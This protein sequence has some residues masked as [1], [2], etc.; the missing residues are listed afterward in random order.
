MAMNTKEKAELDS[1][2]RI[3]E[4]LARD[5]VRLHESIQTMRTIG[6]YERE[7]C[8]HAFELLVDISTGLVYRDIS[9]TQEAAADMV[10]HLSDHRKLNTPTVEVVNTAKK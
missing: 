7:R 8:R 1:I 10:K 9:S 6:D 3:N 4:N 5:N 2:V